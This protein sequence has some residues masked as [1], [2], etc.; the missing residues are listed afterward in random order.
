MTEIIGTQS[1]ARAVGL[2]RIVAEGPA[3]GVTL[4]D[5]AHATGLH[6]ATAHRVLAALTQERLVEQDAAHRYHP[7]VELWIM[8][9]AAARRFDIRALARPALERIATETEDTVY[10]SVRSGRQAICIARCE[11]AF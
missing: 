8:G 7:G 2:L 11:G 10:L 9:E 6:R 3:S 1:I 4:A 5:A